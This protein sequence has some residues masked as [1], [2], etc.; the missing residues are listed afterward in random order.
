MERKLA[1]LLI[2]AA[3]V[4]GLFA[5]VNPAHASTAEIRQAQLRYVADG[6]EAN[7]VTIWQSTVSSPSGPFYIDD[8]G[9]SIAPGAGCWTIS[10]S[11]VGCQG[12]PVTGFLLELKDRDDR[13]TFNVG[14]FADIRGGEGADLLYGGPARD[15]LDGE[16]G[17]DQL[18]GRGGR[19]FPIGRGGDDRLD[20]GPGRDDFHGGSGIDTADYSARTAPVRV[21]L[22]VAGQDGESGEDDYIQ[23]DVENIR[24]GSGDDVLIGSDGGNTLEGNWGID[25][26]DG[27]G[28]NDRL[29]G[30]GGGDTLIGG[31]GLLDY[32]L[33]QTRIGPVAVRIDGVA[34]DGTSSEGDNVE[35]SVEG[36]VGGT[37]NDTLVGNAAV[38]NYLHGGPG[39]DT[40]SGGDGQCGIICVAAVAD[41][42]DGGPHLTGDTVDYSARD[43][44]LSITLDNN[45]DDGRPGENDNA[46]AVENVIGGSGNDYISGNG[47]ANKL[48]GGLGEDGL[49][50]WSGSDL[51]DS[52]DWH[53]DYIYCGDAVDEAFDDDIDIAP[54]GDC[55]TRALLP[56]EI[57]P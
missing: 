38:A 22:L 43:V 40:L 9:A 46:F 21:S 42:L 28:G 11:L 30:G 19:D 33:Y 34:N 32:A 44:P 18:F 53:T 57:F 35:T 8:P 55:E 48:T 20:G 50:G 7:R 10:G 6:G 26:L 56:S 17:D 2:L 49:Y 13:A 41:L 52:R 24:G 39:D 4:I 29:D 45:W 51:I 3:A 25:W 36:V 14:V 15:F 47:S 1:S 54:T 12:G 5:V 23:A 27:A 31:G 37:A 16:G